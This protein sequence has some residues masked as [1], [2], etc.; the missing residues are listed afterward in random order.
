MS[1]LSR[2]GFLSA[3]TAAVASAPA[4]ATLAKAA[5]PG[6]LLGCQTYTFR[7]FD[8]EGALKRMKELGIQHAEFYQK[9]LPLGATGRQLEAFQKLCAEYGVSAR[10]WGV[11]RFTKDHD[12]NRKVFDFAK[13]AGLKVV[14]A[15]PDP[16]SFD[17]LDKCCEETGIAVAIHP[18]G[19]VG[20]GKLHRWADADTILAA[21]KDHH[22]LILSL[23]HI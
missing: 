23:I 2:R 7:E 4:L 5:A 19:P 6:F 17:S 8:L 12:A 15:D 21:V 9:H 14:T 10:A 22:K 16:D 11:Q 13:G 1:N 18:H 3:A 20:G